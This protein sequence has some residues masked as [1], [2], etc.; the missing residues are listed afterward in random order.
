MYITQISVFAENRP[1]S[2]LEISSALQDA[3]INI[4]A[5]TIADT[6]DFGVVR[7]I[8]DKPEEAVR[9]LRENGMAAHKTD[10]IAL[11]A[12]DRPGGMHNALAAL[13]EENAT[14]EYSYGFAVP[15][16]SGAVVILRCRDQERAARA[17]TGRGL[18]LLCADDIF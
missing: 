2:V 11:K 5:M 13:A 1:G 17:L 9:A 10:V 3:K 14:V 12:D 4:R 16:K 8:V 18:T 7:L 15:T 6:T